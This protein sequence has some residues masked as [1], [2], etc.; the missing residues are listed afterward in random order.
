MGRD[1]SHTVLGCLFKV[2]MV[3]GKYKAQT[4]LGDSKFS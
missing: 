4:F 3:P 2:V 1:K